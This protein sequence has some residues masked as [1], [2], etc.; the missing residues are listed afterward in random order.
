MTAIIVDFFADWVRLEKL[1][2][3]NIICLISIWN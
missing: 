2:L 1:V 3:G